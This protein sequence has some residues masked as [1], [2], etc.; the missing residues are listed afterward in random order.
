MDGFWAYC[1]FDRKGSTLVTRRA[2]WFD[3]GAIRSA[4][5]NYRQEQAWP[6]MVLGEPLKPKDKCKAC[7]HVHK[8]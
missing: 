6:P 1:N 3:R 2:H 4:C 7:A 5:L 8:S